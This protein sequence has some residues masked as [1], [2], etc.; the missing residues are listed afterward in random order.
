MNAGTFGG[1]LVGVA[2]A[3]AVKAR[4]QGLKGPLNIKVKGKRFPLA[5]PAHT[6]EDSL[7]MATEMERLSGMPFL[8]AELKQI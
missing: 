3:A 6:I 1:G 8:P 5:I 7:H 4:T 2:T